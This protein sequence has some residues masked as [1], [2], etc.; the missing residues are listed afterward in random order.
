MYHFTVLCVNL[1]GSRE[2]SVFLVIQVFSRNQFHSVVGLRAPF[3][4][5]LSAESQSLASGDCAHCLAHGTSPP[6]SKP[7]TAGRFI[8]T[9]KILPPS[10]SVTLRKR[11]LLL[12][13][14]VIKLG[15][16]G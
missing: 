3:L 2:E 15:P 1:V 10:P 16:P 12:K 5:W 11:S 6:S 13:I 7:T 4:C 8:L 9:L 14:Y